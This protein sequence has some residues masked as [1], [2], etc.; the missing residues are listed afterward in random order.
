MP[1]RLTEVIVDCRDL[2]VEVEFWCAVLGYERGASGDGWQLIRAPGGAPSVAQWTA[3][4]Q[5]PAIAF[6]LVPEAKATKNRLHLDV[7]PIGTTQ[8]EEVE[9]LTGLGATPADVGQRDTPWVVMADPEGNE[10]CVMPG[11][12][13]D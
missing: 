7:T 6:V 5:P 4:A 13:E 11:A 8:A 10:F 2:A 12:T 3:A 1:S 9:R